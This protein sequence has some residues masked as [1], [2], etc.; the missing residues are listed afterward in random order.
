MSH[1]GVRIAILGMVLGIVTPAAPAFAG[2]EVLPPNAK[3]HGY[4]LSDMV[5][6][7]AL[8][9]SSGNN[10]AYYPDTPFQILFTPPGYDPA[11]H[12]P[13][14][15]DKV[16]TGMMLY[17]PLFMSDDS[18]P[19]VG[20]FPD[21]RHQAAVADYYFSQAEVGITIAEIQVDDGEWTT[22][23]RGYAT[24]AATPPLLDGGG[25]HL[26][27]LGAFINPLN[28]GKHTVT[29]RVLATGAAWQAY[30]AFIGVPYTGDTFEV[31]YIVKV[32]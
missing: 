3:P 9:F 2:G 32:H 23:G 31:T 15:F 5:R 30:L 20:D 10:V 24:G 28:R 6:Q 22:L 14:V 16:R 1:R 25:T 13:V 8:F 19:V 26:T 29:I 12:E 4:S 7:S 21:V 18:P 17:V 11:T 27:V